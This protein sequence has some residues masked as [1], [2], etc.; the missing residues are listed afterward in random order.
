MEVAIAL[1][2]FAVLILAWFV[3][4]GSVTIVTAQETPAWATTE[5]LQIAPAEA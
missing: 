1:V 2:L 4:P 5:G 3:L